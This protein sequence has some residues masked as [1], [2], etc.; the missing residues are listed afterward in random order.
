[1]SLLEAFQRE[2]NE[3]ARRVRQKRNDYYTEV[4]SPVHCLVAVG[5]AISFG[6]WLHNF[7]AATFLAFLFLLVEPY[8][9]TTIDR[10]FM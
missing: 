7:Y 5:C 6:A 4:P 3:A 8:L 10:R 2:M 1:M 9:R